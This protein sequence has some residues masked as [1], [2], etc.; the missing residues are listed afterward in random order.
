MCSKMHFMSLKAFLE[1]KQS[2]II[3]NGQGGSFLKEADP[4]GHNQFCF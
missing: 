4:Q 3:V 1:T 2:S